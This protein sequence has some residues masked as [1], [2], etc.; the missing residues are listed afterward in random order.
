MGFAQPRAAVDEK[1]VVVAVAGLFGDGLGNGGGKLV[2]FADHQRVKGVIGRQVGLG[3]PLLGRPAPAFGFYCAGFT[4]FGGGG[5]RLRFR[6]KVIHPLGK[7]IQRT[8][9]FAACGG[10]DRRS[11][12]HFRAA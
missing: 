3:V 12:L 2:T 8:R 11:G 6:A 5:F 10:F 7:D 4:L 9:F 1:R